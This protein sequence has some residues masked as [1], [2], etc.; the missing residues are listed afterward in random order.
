MSVNLVKIVRLAFIALLA[1]AAPNPA[2]AQDGAQYFMIMY[3]YQNW[4]NAAAYSHTYAS[5][6]RVDAGGDVARVDIS[7]IPQ[8][9][10]LP[11]PGD[12]RMP[13]LGD[14]PGQNMSIPATNARAAQAFPAREVSMFGAFPIRPE[15][16]YAQLAQSRRLFSGAVTY[17]G[18]DMNSRPYSVNCVHAVADACGDFRT[19]ISLRGP[20]ASWALAQYCA[21]RGLVTSLEARRDWATYLVQQSRRIG[22]NPSL[23]AD[24]VVSA[25]CAQ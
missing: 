8:D 10:Y 24:D 18:L 25:D 14:W 7:W 3:G 20:T 1:L 11:G 12:L 16:F 13:A 19:G 15:L 21:A 5:F 9:A 22:C 17:R 6:F 4:R 23:P 2:A